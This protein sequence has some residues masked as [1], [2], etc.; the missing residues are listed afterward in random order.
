MKQFLPFALPLSVFL[1]CSAASGQDA[2]TPRKK[3]RVLD[4]SSWPAM[5]KRGEASGGWKIHDMK[6]PQP[7]FV[8][9]AEQPSLPAPA[10]AV[11][12]FDGKPET[13]AKHWTN[14][15]WKIV[16]GAMRTRNG[17][18]NTATRLALGDCQLHVE[19]R[20]VG[21]SP[22]M[23]NSGIMFMDAKYEIQ[24][25]D[26][27]P[28][29]NILGADG[30]AGAV[31]GWMPPLVN[32]ILPHDHWNAYDIVF[33]RPRFDDKGACV[34]KARVT[35]HFNGVLVQDNVEFPGPT[36]WVFRPPYRKHA[37]KLPLLLQ[38]HGGTL[39]F[40]NIWVRE[41]E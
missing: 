16:D 20:G 6:R 9:V 3:V 10:D 23:N 14:A 8:Q 7:R 4:D 24:I 30:M 40:R 27:H 18:G 37:D 15:K 29:C 17:D 41:L 11:V 39:E 12:L 32:P 2:A 33:H 13:M 25:A 19:W 35:V 26:S 36:N 21:D 28:D 31:Y 34:Q 5:D 22:D 1:L 38:S